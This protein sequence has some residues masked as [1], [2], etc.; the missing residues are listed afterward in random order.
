MQWDTLG[1]PD[2]VPRWSAR[3]APLN[4]VFACDEVTAMATFGRLDDAPSAASDQRPER[5]TGDAGK[6]APPVSGR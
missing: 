4:S 5:T 3:R 6:N 2:R 1:R